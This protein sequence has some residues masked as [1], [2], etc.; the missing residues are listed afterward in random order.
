M[1]VGKSSDS[2]QKERTMESI[3]QTIGYSDFIDLAP[4]FQLYR[5]ID[6][7]TKDQ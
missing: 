7:T 5:L 2:A 1:H 4:E 6:E 3:G